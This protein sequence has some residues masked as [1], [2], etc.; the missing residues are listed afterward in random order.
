MT[1]NRYANGHRR[2]TL[3]KQVLAEEEHCWIC[4]RLV[5]KDLHHLHPHSATLDE[6][7]PVSKGGSP[8]ERS[9]VRLACRRCNIKRGDGT[10]QRQRPIIV[11]FVSSRTW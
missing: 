1:I 9:N 11:P 6:I 4:G 2:R 5:N 8:Y 3:R 7:V 10:R